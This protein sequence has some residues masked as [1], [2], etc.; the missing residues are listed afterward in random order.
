[1]RGEPMPERVALPI[2]TARPPVQHLTGD[3]KR[4]S[5]ASATPA[6]AFRE[7]RRPTA[8]GYRYRNIQDTDRSNG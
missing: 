3:K 1:M 5:P 2:G 4:L 7:L 6:P 8:A